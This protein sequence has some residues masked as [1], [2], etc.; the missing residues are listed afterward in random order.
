MGAALSGL[1]TGLATGA[2]AQPATGSGGAGDANAASA[3]DEGAGGR[4]LVG[5]HGAGADARAYR[6]YVPA[7]GGAGRP[8]LVFLHGCTQDAADAM[9][10][11]RLNAV[12][13]RERFLVLYPEQPASANPQRCWSWFDPRHQGRDAGEPATLAGMTRAVMQTQ[14]ADTGRV[15][16][17]GISAGGAMALVLAATH[18]DLYASV[19]SHS[20]VPFA[21]ADGPVRAWQ[22]MK[23]GGGADPSPVRQA[24]G[25]RARS[26]PLLVLHGSADAV[27]VAA[28]GRQ[29]AAQW[30]A[31]IGASVEEAD[32]ARAMGGTSASAPAS[33]S[34]STSATSAAAPTDARAATRTRW[35]LAAGGPPLVELIEIAGLGHAWSGGSPEG[36]FTDPA[37]PAASEL[38]AAWMRAHALAPAPAPAP[39][40]V[41]ARA[42]P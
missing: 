5:S 37:G 16:V 9:R 33:A 35:C 34:A 31:A 14:G 12:A 8:L 21:A 24:M 32:V 23:Q 28:N 22:V 4:V 39:A 13:G 25:A 10:G 15:H 6:L 42:R 7:G 3:V 19:A 2:D 20:G 38:V 1:T 27:V 29:T 41:G 36:T 11:T 30:A 17:A 26:V 40:P 18:P